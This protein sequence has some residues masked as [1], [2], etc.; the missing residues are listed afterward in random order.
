MMCQGSV[1]EF[2]GYTELIGVVTDRSQNETGQD[3]SE[4]ERDGTGRIGVGTRQDRTDRSGV[5]TRRDGTERGRNK[6]T[7]ISDN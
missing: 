6:K 4:S 1:A 5:G 7:K 2:V 3:V